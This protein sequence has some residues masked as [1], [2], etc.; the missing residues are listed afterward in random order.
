VETYD[1]G[2]EH[3]ILG[4]L[5]LEVSVGVA[6]YPQDG[7]D[8]ATLLSVADAR[9]YASK[10]QRKL[11]KMTHRR[12]ELPAGDLDKDSDIDLPHAA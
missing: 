2:L 12:M 8:C 4:A 6:C 11:G 3:E 1:A 9:M 5:S 10:T 7:A